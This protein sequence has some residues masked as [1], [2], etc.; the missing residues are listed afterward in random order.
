MI[1]S[2]PAGPG[3]QSLCRRGPGRAA[4]LGVIMPS[5]GRPPAEPGIWL[6]AACSEA[7]DH[8]D[9]GPG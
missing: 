2:G 3:A 1:W 9:D 5:Q 8:D 7:A 4:A 6:N